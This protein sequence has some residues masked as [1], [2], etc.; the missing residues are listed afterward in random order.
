VELLWKKKNRELIVVSLYARTLRDSHGTVIGYEG[1]VLDITERKRMEEALRQSEARYRTISELVSDYA[2]AVRIEHDGRTMVEWVTEAFS[3][4]TGFTVQELEEGGGIVRVIHP[5][6]MPNVLQRLCVLLAGQ[7]GVSEHRIIT[8]S[9]AVRWLRDYSC[10]EWDPAQGRVVRIIGAGQDITERKQAEAALRESEERYRNLFENANDMLATFALDGTVTSVNRGLE[11]ALGWSREELIGQPYSKLTT[12]AALTLADEYTQR[13]LAG[14]KLPSIFETEIVRKD[15]NVVPI[16]VRARFIRDAE[17]RPIGIQGIFRDLT[18]RRQAE[19][20]VLEERSRM[21]REIHDALAQG[22]AGIILHLEAAK[23]TLT[24]APEKAQACLD[25]ACTLARESLAE[26]RRSVRALR[27]QTLEQ[28][29]LLT[30]LARL[31]AKAQA[32]TQPRIAFRLRGTPHPLPAE[33]ELNL[34]R[35]SQEALHNA[36]KH[37]RARNIAIDLV[38]G[39]QQVKLC[40]QDDGRGFATRR[41]T[42]SDDFGM[43][44]MQER[45]ERIGGRFTL[46]SR[47]G[48]GTKVVVIVPNSHPL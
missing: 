46:T 11:V 22:F 25:E 43:T 48:K 19:A 44:S 26:A 28:N 41:A 35:I 23:R 3:C 4:I 10:P 45:V 32:D 31:I 21:A 8:K 39:V 40:V 33:V 36:C 14:E 1:M 37:A 34:L 5:E 20:A 9:G 42:C 17:K 6:D 38:F 18:E 24:R 12:P 16:E 30:A 15:G 13:A 29:G 7:P 2:Y 27:P 47:L